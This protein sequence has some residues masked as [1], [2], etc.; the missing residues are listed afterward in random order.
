MC[1]GYKG[2]SGTMCE[3][4]IFKIF[5]EENS[6]FLQ[7]FNSILVSSTG[8]TIKVHAKLYEKNYLA[9]GEEGIMKTKQTIKIL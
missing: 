2:M 3:Y 1:F 9:E 5:Y 8:S 4:L 7:D 6:C